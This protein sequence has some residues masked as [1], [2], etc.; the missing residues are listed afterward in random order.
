MRVR[1]LAGDLAAMLGVIVGDRGFD[2]VLDAMVLP[3][4]GGW[5]CSS[6]GAPIIA[7]RAPSTVPSL[8]CP[9]CIERRTARERAA[10]A[11]AVGVAEARISQAISKV[12]AVAPQTQAELD[13]ATAELRQ[14]STHLS[15]VG[16]G[17]AGSVTDG[18]LT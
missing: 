5:Q 4:L 7:A 18:S 11:L 13:E 15:G 17:P 10:I 1:G 2:A 14:L 3:D 6:C 9:C 12:P 8:E 16:G